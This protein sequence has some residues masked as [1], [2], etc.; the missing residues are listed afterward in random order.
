VSELNFPYEREKL[1]LLNRHPQL[2]NFMDTH[3]KKMLATMG[4]FESLSTGY[5]KVDKNSF[6]LV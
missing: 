4:V 1:A 6:R 5:L 2:E 3:T